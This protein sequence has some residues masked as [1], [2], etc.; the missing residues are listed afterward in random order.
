[1][2]K[3]KIK[4][5]DKDK[6][7]KEYQQNVLKLSQSGAYCQVG[8]QGAPAA[9]NHNKSPGITIADIANIH[10]YGKTFTVGDRTIVIPQRSFIRAAVDEFHN[11]IQKRATL[12]GTGVVLLKF[13]KQQGLELIG[14]YAVGIMKQ[15]IADRIS[16]PNRPSTKKRK[17]SDVPLIDTG[18]LRGAITYKIEAG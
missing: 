6:G 10:E 5:I 2:A 11:A 1:M 16:P 8:V 17:G 4:V 7:W 14:A 3:G 9:A 15:R 13:T 18:Q 12:I